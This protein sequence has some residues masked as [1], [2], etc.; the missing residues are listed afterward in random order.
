MII[1]KGR[2][3]P[4]DTYY[5]KKKRTGNHTVGAVSA[6]AFYVACANYTQTVAVLY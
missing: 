1:S 3:I 2:V 6:H 4:M 5:D